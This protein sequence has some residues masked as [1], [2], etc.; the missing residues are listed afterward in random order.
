MDLTHDDDETNSPISDFPLQ[1]R[2]NTIIMS[3]NVVLLTFS[4]AGHDA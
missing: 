3:T 1:L 4:Y 2:T